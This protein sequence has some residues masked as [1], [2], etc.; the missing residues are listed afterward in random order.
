M[1][2]TVDNILTG[3]SDHFSRPIDH[4]RS[5]RSGKKFD[6][7]K[8]RSI[9]GRDKKWRSREPRA[10]ENF[11][12]Q[13]TGKDNSDERE[14]GYHTFEIYKASTACENDSF[15]FPRD[16]LSFFEAS[17]YLRFLTRLFHSRKL[18]FLYDTN[19]DTQQ[20]GERDIERRLC[21]FFE[22]SDY[23]APRVSQMRAWRDI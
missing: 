15:P 10:C 9:N 19:K 20:G 18:A 2:R 17:Q 3:S 23:S 22:F 13:R 21:R 6:G 4:R 8:N 5:V 12:S 16:R 11:I 7:T 14:S 1:G